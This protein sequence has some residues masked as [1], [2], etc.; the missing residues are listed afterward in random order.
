MSSNGVWYS[1]SEQR[2][3]NVVAASAATVSAHS[4]IGADS[5]V[6]SL[7]VSNVSYASLVANASL[8]GAFEL[9]IKQAIV[10]TSGG[11]THIEH[12]ALALSPASVLV[13][14]TI[15]SLDSSDIRRIHSALAENTPLA[16]AVSQRIVGIQGMATVSAGVVSVNVGS[17]II[18]R[19]ANTSTTSTTPTRRNFDRNPTSVPAGATRLAVASC[20]SQKLFGNSGLAWVLRKAAIIPSIL[21]A[22]P[23]AIHAMLG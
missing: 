5:V 15:E 21:A 10:S 16:S 23:L 4:L 19:V 6:V 2:Y 22:F 17:V 13:Q 18:R 8:I 7:M 11:G 1:S 14:A 3:H 20:S 12:V 9:A